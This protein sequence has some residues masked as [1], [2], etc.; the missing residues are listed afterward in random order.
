MPSSQHD[1]G[2]T[3]EKCTFWR[4][5]W[6]PK[7]K[8]WSLLM[9]LWCCHDNIFPFRQLGRDLGAFRC[10]TETAPSPLLIFLPTS[11][12][13][14]VLAVYRLKIILCFIIDYSHY[15]YFLKTFK[16]PNDFNYNTFI[17]GNTI[18]F[19]LRLGTWH[20]L[21]CCDTHWAVFFAGSAAVLPDGTY[22]FHPRNAMELP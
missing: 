21:F 5:F 8:E 10:R 3:E 18:D 20:F 11:H 1:I 13:F 17:M 15:K 4:Q 19:S 6:N 7:L 14:K 2:N 16:S 12:V 9:A 22:T